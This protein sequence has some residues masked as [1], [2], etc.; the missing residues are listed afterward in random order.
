MSQLAE[1]KFG[2]GARIAF[3]VSCLLALCASGQAETETR[4]THGSN[5]QTVWIKNY[6][7]GLFFGSCGPSTHSLQW[8]YTSTLEGAGPTF[9]PK[10]ITLRDGN[11]KSLPVEAG[12]VTL[13][14]AGKNVTIDLR[15]S[16]DSTA[17]PVPHNG[18]YK[19][20]K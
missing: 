12:T 3:M 18:S 11:L 9:P 1:V 8:E 15:V 5:Q 17:V 7:R 6:R 20:K 10:Q 16:Q 13:D 19:V 4:I 14:A 2:T